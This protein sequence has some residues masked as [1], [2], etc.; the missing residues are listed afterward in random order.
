MGAQ[1]KLLACGFFFKLEPSIARFM[2]YL[3]HTVIGLLFFF[4]QDN[5]LKSASLSERYVKYF[6][7]NF[8][9]VMMDA[10]IAVA[11]MFALEPDK[12]QC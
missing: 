1:F 12:K 4:R 11:V 3:L 6:W 9:T 7:Y 8:L 5:I 2:I 10:S